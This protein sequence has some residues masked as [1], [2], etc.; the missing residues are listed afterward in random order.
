MEYEYFLQPV[1]HLDVNRTSESLWRKPQGAEAW[2]YRSLI[3]GD[4]HAVDP[5]EKIPRVPGLGELQKITPAQA[6]VLSSDRSRWNLYWARYP[7]VPEVGETARSVVRRKASPEACLDEVFGRGDVWKTTRDIREACSL[8]TSNPPHIQPVDWATAQ[9]I[10]REARGP[11][12]AAKMID[13]YSSDRVS[14]QNAELAKAATVQS[15]SKGD[16]S[17]PAISPP[18]NTGTPAVQPAEHRGHKKL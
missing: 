2:E 6:A 9:K 12:A 18:Q 5:V 4:W 1:K 16:H 17:T 8:R 11:A 3:D 10:I 14:Q 15:V 13:V 7:D